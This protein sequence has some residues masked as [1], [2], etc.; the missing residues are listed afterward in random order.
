MLG[1]GEYS[2]I[3]RVIGWTLDQQLNAREPLR[4]EIEVRGAAIVVS[5]EAPESPEQRQTFPASD[6]DLLRVK[7]RA[8]RAGDMTGRAG[9]QAEFLRTIGRISTSTASHWSGSSKY[10]RVTD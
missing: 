3:L 4:V 5:W 2:D 7:A 8:L 1:P 10:P 6:L 9:E